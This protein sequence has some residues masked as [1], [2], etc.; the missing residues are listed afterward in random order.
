M[1]LFMK[2]SL[3]AAVTLFSFYSAD[4]QEV[5]SLTVSNYPTARA[6]NE[7]PT[8]PATKQEMTI[9][10]KN[11]AEKPVIIFAG[12]KED[13]RNPKVQTFGGLSKN[14]LYV[15]PNDVVC[16]MTHETKPMSC[17]SVKEGVTILEINTS[18]TSI[19]TK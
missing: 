1:K 19:V 15:Q 14:T 6:I 16:L 18:G 5:A 2:L 3:C 13:I 7:N 11:S 9:T 8:A 10:L 4:A 12:P 17:A